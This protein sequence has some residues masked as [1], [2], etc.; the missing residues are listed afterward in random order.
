MTI[1]KS[2][3]ISI[4]EAGYKQLGE[5]RFVQL[6]HDADER[7]IALNPTEETDLDGY[8]VRRQNASKGTGPAVIS[9]GN[10]ASDCG[11]DTHQARRWAPELIDGMLV[12]D[13]KVEGVIVISN[14]ERGRLAREGGG[15]T[16]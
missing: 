3:A 7:L 13:L 9:A 2:G 5:P 15:G 4:N 10:F 14:R 1:Q 6:L 8:A 16:Q 11:V 12:V